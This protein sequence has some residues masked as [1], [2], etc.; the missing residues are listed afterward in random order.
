M[1]ALEDAPSHSLDCAQL[2]NLVPAHLKPAGAFKTAVAAVPGVRVSVTGSVTTAT[3][4]RGGSSSVAGLTTLMSAASL[5]TATDP[6]PAVVPL[7]APPSIPAAVVAAPSAPFCAAVMSALER[8]PSRTLRLTALGTLIPTNLKPAGAFKTA[9]AAIPGVHVHID[10]AFST[11]TLEGGESDDDDDG[12]DEQ[13]M[14]P[15]APAVQGAAPED[16]TSRLAA[17]VFAPAAVVPLVAPAAVIAAPSASFCTAV[18]SALEDAPSRSLDL[19]QLGTIVPAHLKP[20]GAFKTAVALVPG[21]RVS[22]DG[23]VAVASLRWGTVA[24]STGAA[25]RP[26]VPAP[27]DAPV[28]WGEA[29]AS[30]EIMF[31]VTVRRILREA[32]GRS[33]LPGLGSQLSRIGRPPGSLQ[34]LLS[35]VDGVRLVEPSGPGGGYAELVPQ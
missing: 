32:G 18:V 27:T 6:R 2:G 3:L 22:I 9:V 26:I 11:A 14:P 28:A 17:P 30:S 34:A 8:A 19:A 31:G 12:D 10:G 33:A 16:A 20:A 29:A 35:R 25:P 23:T 1:S 21:V 15:A 13:T 5:S 7:V 24:P 4:E